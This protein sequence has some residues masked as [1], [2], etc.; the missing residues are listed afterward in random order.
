[1]NKNS[2][3][4]PYKR[5]SF[6]SENKKQK[7]LG[8]LKE[9]QDKIEEQQRNLEKRLNDD[10]LA[11]N[12]AGDTEQKEKLNKSILEK[13][14]Q[15]RE[16]RKESSQLNKVASIIN[17]DDL[18]EENNLDH[19]EN[20]P[21]TKE[22]NRIKTLY[23]LSKEEQEKEITPVEK[24]TVS[25]VDVQFKMNY[26][27]GKGEE[28]DAVADITKRDISIHAR[29][30]K[31]DKALQSTP[32][33][34]I[35]NLKKIKNKL[36]RSKSTKIKDSGSAPAEEEET[37]SPQEEG[38]I[39]AEEKS[40]PENN[41]E[42]NLFIEDLNQTNKNNLPH[43]TSQNLNQKL[44]VS[45]V[46]KP[47]NNFTSTSQKTT[48]NN[49]QASIKDTFKILSLDKNLTDQ[50]VNTIRFFGHFIADILNIY[51][52]ITWKGHY[53]YS[54]K[55]NFENFVRIS[56]IIHIL[57]YLWQKFNLPFKQFFYNNTRDIR[58]YYINILI[59]QLTSY[60]VRMS[61]AL[62]A[63]MVLNIWHIF[64]FS[65]L[66]HPQHIQSF[67]ETFRETFRE[68][69]PAVPEGFSFISLFFQD[70]ILVLSLPA[71]FSKIPKFILFC[72]S[73][74]NSYFNIF[75][76]D[77]R[78]KAYPDIIMF[79]F[80]LATRKLRIELMPYITEFDSI[81]VDFFK[82]LKLLIKRFIKVL[83]N[84]FS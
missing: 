60:C 84:L 61:V 23:S 78:E 28:V 41:K 50:D 24:D 52:V 19:K 35:K 46:S 49:N 29:S 82:S 66:F 26:H 80:V 76:K 6:A 22:P 33:K 40:L 56:I 59:Y 64:P 75:S 32:G 4:K 14:A 13:A 53:V 37:I 72:V 81:I 18:S 38:P 79:I 62:L 83:Y 10:S 45:D 20:P 68:T 70:L 34:V 5:P 9:K 39:L 31:L 21:V 1:M 43:D 55:I 71:C 11:R 12:N 69:L 58:Q 54:G 74:L 8:N 77:N 3:E 47:S 17:G 42:E 30:D 51:N 67:I 44:K 73:W 16:L 63:G 7:Y 57:S 65:Q 48:D 2:T 27:N 25:A 36:T 15:L